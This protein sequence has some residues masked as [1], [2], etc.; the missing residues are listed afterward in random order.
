MRAPTELGRG[1]AF[2]VEAV[3]RPR[4]DE[5]VYRL[6]HVGDLSVALADVDHL[7]AAV[8]RQHRVVLVG[9]RLLEGRNVGGKATGQHGRGDLGEGL[10]GEVADEAGVGAV[11]EHGGSTLVVA[12]PGDHATDVHVPHVQRAVQRMRRGQILVGVPQLNA[13]VEIANAVIATPLQDRGV[14]DVPGKVEQQVAISDPGRKELV[15][16]VGGDLVLLIGHARRDRIGDAGT[17]VDHVDDRDAL[18]ID[19]QIADQQ[20]HRALG[21]GT[22]AQHQN[23]LGAHG[24]SAN[25]GVIAASS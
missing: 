3:D 13:G 2:F 20:W 4:V 12:P 7:G 23:A 8:H 24:Y 15:E 16:V 9:E 5:L 17:V 22:T 21:T 18:R 6:R 10:L 25:S 1:D 14:V 19:L 11:L